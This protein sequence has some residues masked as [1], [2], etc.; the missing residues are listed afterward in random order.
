MQ[1]RPEPELMDDPAQA[2][3]YAEADFSEPHEAFVAYFRQR[4]PEFRDGRVLDLGCGP[5][6][7]TMRFACAYPD[8]QVLGIDGAQAMLALG[9]QAVLA[10]GLAGRI[11]LEHHRLPHPLP[12]HFDAIISNSLLHH[13]PDPMVLWQSIRACGKPGAAVLVMDLARP[14]DDSAASQLVEAHAGEAPMLLK[15]DFHHSLLAAYRPEEVWQ[16]LQRAELGHFRVET[17][18]D[19]HFIVWGRR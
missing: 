9:R 17:V 3:A 1:R 14:N 10:A 12:S 15:R 19:R 18:S 11:V 2:A 4:F 5:A 6:D 13:L 7:V 8:A 16:Q